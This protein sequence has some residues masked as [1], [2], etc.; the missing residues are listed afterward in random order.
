MDELRASYVEW[1]KRRAKYF[2]GVL[3]RYEDG[4]EVWYCEHHG[5]HLTPGDAIECAEMELMR[6]QE[7]K[8][9]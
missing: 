2:R 7:G 3:K 5:D 4:R 9:S 8:R 1:G 6:R